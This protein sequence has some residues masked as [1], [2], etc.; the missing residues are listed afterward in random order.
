MK[1]TTDCT[2]EHRHVLSMCVHE[3]AYK[4]ALLLRL[5]CMCTHTHKLQTRTRNLK[6]V[7][8]GNFNFSKKIQLTQ[9]TNFKS[10][11]YFIFQHQ[12]YG[13][14]CYRRRNVK[15]LNWDYLDLVAVLM[16]KFITTLKDLA[17]NKIKRLL[18]ASLLHSFQYGIV[19]SN[20]Q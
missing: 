3:K 14:I 5:Q 4:M 17:I 12:G 1:K 8:K 2:T 18:V 20:S 16:R 13:K 11:F 10:I 15:K 19:L 6:E 9:Q 7:Q